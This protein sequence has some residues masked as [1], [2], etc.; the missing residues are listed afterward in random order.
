MHVLYLDLS[1]LFS[2][3]ESRFLTMHRLR[4]SSFLTDVKALANLSFV[5]NLK[6][7]HASVDSNM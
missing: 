5:L 7:I 3:L 4:F 1:F 2:L 6:K